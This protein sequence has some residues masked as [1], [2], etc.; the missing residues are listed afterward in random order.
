V[1]DTRVYPSLPR[2]LGPRLASFGPACHIIRLRPTPAGT[3]A[4]Y[5]AHLP[6]PARVEHLLGAYHALPET[7]RGVL[8]AMAVAYMPLARTYLVNV[9]GRAGIRT[10]QGAKF[11]AAKLEPLI[12]RLIE[13]GLAVRED[14]GAVCH[15][16]CVEAVTRA[17]QAAGRLEP[18]AAAIKE[19]VRPANSR[20]YEM[21]QSDLRLAVYRGDVEEAVDAL[22]RCY[23]ASPMQ[24]RKHHPLSFFLA[25]PFDRS[26][27]E[28][29]PIELAA[30]GLEAYLEHAVKGL[31][32]AKEASELLVSLAAGEDAE[33][34]DLDALYG[35]QLVLRGRA[36]QAR[37]RLTEAQSSEALA[38]A[39]MA[40]LVLGEADAAAA[41]F[42][43]ALKRLR[44][45]TGRRK[46]VLPS[47]ASAMYAI[48]LMGDGGQGHLAAAA[49]YL[50]P[51]KTGVYPHGLES[52]H[53]ALRLAVEALGGRQ[54][55]AGEWPK[56]FEVGAD[57]RADLLMGVA[58]C[59]V[60][61][62]A[63]RKLRD[64]LARLAKRGE[65]AGYLWLAAEA[66]AVLVRMG[67][68][69][70]AQQAER[71]ARQVP[72][73]RLVD[74]MRPRPAWERALEALSDL[75]VE[76]A[77]KAAAAEKPA[78]L[79]WWVSV[80][81]GWINPA[82]REQVRTTKGTWSKGRPVALRRLAEDASRLD[83]LT[84]QDRRVCRHIHS[85]QGW[86]GEVTYQLDWVAA[87]RELVGHP[88][89][90]RQDDPSVPLELLLRRPTLE[91]VEEKDGHV[92]VALDPPLDG[93]SP[94]RVVEETRGRIA[95]IEAGPAHRRMAAILQG[96]LRI[97]AA[98]REQL[99]G[100]LEAVAPLV[101]VH[102]D[103]VGTGGQ[104][105]QVAAS[106]QPHL[107]LSPLGDGVK[108]QLRVRPFGAAGP[109]L[110][111]GSGGRAVITDV[112]GRRLATERDLKAERR[113][114][115]ELVTACK[116]L[117]E[118]PEMDGEWDLDDPAQALE[119]LA[120]LAE[121]GDQVRVEWPE[122]A[123]LKLAGRA[124]LDRWRVS[125][126]R[127]KEW[128]AAS[129]ELKVDEERVLDM[130]RLLELL[131]QGVGR[132]L[133]L[134][135]GEFLALS[136]T[137]RARLADLRALGEAG[138]KGLRLSPLAAP[139]L[140][141]LTEGATLKGDR[142]WR[143]QL[144]RL[145]AAQALEP[146]VPSTLQAELR[147]YQVEGYRWLA[148]LA[149]WGAGACLADDMGLGKT[150][151]T[152]ALLLARAEQGPALVVAPT[153]VAANWHQ[154]A[155]RFAPTLNVIPFGPGD[156]Q[157]VLDGLGPFDLLVASY[158]LLQQE[159]QRLAKVSF[160]S[161]VLDEA[162]AI[163]N[164]VTQRAKA[165]FALDGSF[166]LVTTGTP[167]ENHLGELW[168]LFRFVNPGLLGSRD[169]FDNRYAKPI[170]RDNDRSARH[171]LRRLIQ[172][173]VLRRL[174]S[175]V[176]D[177]LPPRT[178]VVLHVDPSPDEAAF[179]EALRRRA[180]EQLDALPTADGQ[181]SMH[182][183][184]EITRL[185]RA[186]CHPRLVDPASGLTGSKLALFAEVL[187]ELRE[188]RHKAL[189][190]SQFI[191]HLA[192][193]R[194]HLDDHAIAYQ[195]LDGST[196]AAERAKRVKA[197]QAGQGEVFLISLKAGGTG[198]NLTA[199][200][201]VI[202]LDPWWNPAVED[203]AADRAHRIGQS[204]PVTVY[205]LVARGTIEDRIVALHG[206]KRDLA[207]GLLAGT[208]HAG[209]ISAEDLLALIREG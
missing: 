85:E 162:Q 122:G 74:R 22:A 169:G 201:Y 34:L 47:L 190:F 112:E 72:G 155:A 101:T 135:E 141:E 94:H 119:L 65:Q 77:P 139:L 208:D 57:P 82:P 103:I 55:P 142:H 207:D 124:G 147:D 8:E 138:P 78:R 13:A 40:E 167:V 200:D 50:E 28:G 197:F 181:R 133:P 132:F 186:A 168:S 2:H 46:V 118:M 194:A 158:G 66:A 176:L 179:Y 203:Q 53:N 102:S 150:V 30:L 1:N 9:L 92:R 134:G 151:Q 83:F 146:E 195:Y 111:P 25:E 27:W 121:R 104:A 24:A 126:K 31:H 120:D 56:P 7:E 76:S 199:A 114:A 12:D 193:A 164:P 79:V 113:R 116:T 131:E 174:K 44:A 19:S 177:E 59:W 68:N 127:D 48:A 198:L 52:V 105:E 45:E 11:T 71:L 145:S 21:A 204:R 91:V 202:H 60:G 191:D 87:A 39:A 175:Q 159:A 136:E 67:D 89:L 16:D 109:Y 64:A 54:V 125:V 81:E 130:A 115:D 137:L 160:A 143:E 61:V 128:L 156:R 166:R 183:L 148:Q 73:P 163:K 32:P 188:G 17:V 23:Q 38:A 129:G 153:S 15:P 4:L 10:A 108:A 33:A 14:G 43:D 152:L 178:E 93:E 37:R 100:A 5:D 171:R 123:R 182:I 98:A 29:L 165:A 84:A 170:E 63:P 96:G 35:E 97:P 196:S 205:R 107:L 3:P 49:R 206:K 187:D 192:L 62:D 110:A 51:P 90:F 173:F 189:V 41:R 117:A 20:L 95:F 86:Y 185:R 42:A 18:L 88:L 6:D 144:Q 184:A 36:E 80:G 149:H 99:Q 154:E 58:A 69:D 209:R 161:I 106:D 75:P 172:P 180:V 70:F 157:A 140:E 26:W